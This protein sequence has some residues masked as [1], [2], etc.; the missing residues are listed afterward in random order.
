MRGWRQ[1]S[2]TTEDKFIKHH[3]SVHIIRKSP[4]YT[5][6]KWHKNREHEDKMQLI[7]EN[8]VLESENLMDKQ[9]TEIKIVS[10]EEENDL[11]SEE[12]AYES[13]DMEEFICNK[14]KKLFGTD[15]ELTAHDEAMCMLYFFKESF[16]LNV[17][18]VKLVTSEF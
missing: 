13:D 15:E 8:N 9:T 7:Q 17:V 18:I 12:S 16:V 5:A 4:E 3:L 14:C 6:L 2:L 11:E 10:E 1:A